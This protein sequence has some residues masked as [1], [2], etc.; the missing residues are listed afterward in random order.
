MS[1]EQYYPAICSPAQLGPS[2]LSLGGFVFT[3]SRSCAPLTLV[4]HS[5][6]IRALSPLTR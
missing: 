5:L 2:P 3:P 1:A 6:H 4:F